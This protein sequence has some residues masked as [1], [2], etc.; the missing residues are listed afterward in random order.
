MCLVNTG[1]LGHHQN[2]SCLSLALH[3]DLLLMLCDRGFAAEGGT[4]KSCQPTLREA[5]KDLW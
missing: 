3:V 4:G 5:A 2:P 1:C